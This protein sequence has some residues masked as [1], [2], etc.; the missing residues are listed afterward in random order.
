MVCQTDRQSGVQLDRGICYDGANSALLSNRTATEGVHELRSE[1]TAALKASQG[2]PAVF[3]VGATSDRAQQAGDGCVAHVLLHSSHGFERSVICTIQTEP[4]FKM[5]L[6]FALF[7]V[8]II[9]FSDSARGKENELYTALE[10][11]CGLCLYICSCS[12]NT[13]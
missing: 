5:E 11:V 3:G 2:A 7:F 12:S 9:A 6:Q 1:F 8:G 13:L 4:V 10:M